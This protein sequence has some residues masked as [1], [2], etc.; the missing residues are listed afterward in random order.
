MVSLTLHANSVYRL[1]NNKLQR[2]REMV[3]ADHTYPPAIWTE[4]I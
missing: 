2:I 3:V 1:A 4:V